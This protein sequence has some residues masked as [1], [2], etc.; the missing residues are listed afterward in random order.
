[1]RYCDLWIAVR[2]AAYTL[3]EDAWHYDAEATLA[4][5]STLERKLRTILDRAKLDAMHH[6]K[7]TPTYG[8]HEEDYR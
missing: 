7:S 2:D 4:S 8:G 5:I 3:R 1:M 6:E